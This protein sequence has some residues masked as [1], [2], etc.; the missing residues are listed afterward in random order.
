LEAL[1]DYKAIEIT[2]IHTHESEEDIGST[3]TSPA[4]KSPKRYHFR[5]VDKDSNG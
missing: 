2:E 4:K 3:D 5:I 1:P